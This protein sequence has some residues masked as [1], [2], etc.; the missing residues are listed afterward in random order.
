MFDKATKLKLRFDSPKG[1]LSV[2]DLWDLPLQTKVP[3]KASLDEIAM[4][5]DSE[6][7]TTGVKSF[8]T[9][10]TK[11]NSVVSL[12]LD[13]VK[14]IIEQKLAE[15]AA[16]RTERDAKE[17]EQKILG[18]I[19]DKRDDQLKGKSIEELEAMLVKA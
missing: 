15:N 3:N 11:T 19:A 12:K 16:E 8:V 1:Q 18:L 14:Y 2:E 7:Q 9:N 6:L 5:L 13:V 17:R 4:N 10:S